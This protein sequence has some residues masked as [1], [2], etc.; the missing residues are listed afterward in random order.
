MK[1]KRFKD[2]IGFYV[3]ILVVLLAVI[4]NVNLAFAKPSIIQLMRDSHH[5]K[6]VP[7][8]ALLFRVHKG[9]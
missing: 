6:T 1:M 8:E 2:T 4:S 3:V 9:F 5:G 7:G